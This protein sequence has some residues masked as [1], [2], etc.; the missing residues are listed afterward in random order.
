[1][2]AGLKSKH[3]TE[4][5]IVA[6]LNSIFRYLAA[7]ETVQI[8]GFGTFETRE[9][10]AHIGRNTVTGES[11]TI[12]ARTMPLFRTGKPHEAPIKAKSQID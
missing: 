2:R 8:I 6:L 3:V 12:S 5:A 9:R 11:I 4:E 1:M 7:S 10:S